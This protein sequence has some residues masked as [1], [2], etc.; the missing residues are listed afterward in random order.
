MY[1]LGL[2]LKAE[3]RYADAVDT[4]YRAAWDYEYAS[5]AYFQL[6]Q[7]SSFTGD[8]GRALQEAQMAVAYNGMNLDARNLLTTLLRR[9]G[10]Q[11]EAARIAADVVAFDPLNYYATYEL[12]NPI[13]NWR[14]TT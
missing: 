2:I 6:A 12:A 13:W 3:G 5:A 7:I 9:S 14:S 11:E 1:N 4:L 10:R 8:S